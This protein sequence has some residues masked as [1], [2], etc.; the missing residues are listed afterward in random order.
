MLGKNDMKAIWNIHVIAG[1]G[2]TIVIESNHYSPLESV[3]TEY[4]V[5]GTTVTVCSWKCE[6]NYYDVVVDDNEN[7]DAEWYYPQRKEEVSEIE[8]YTA[9]WC[10]VQITN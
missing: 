10:G 6:S 1:S 3:D 8:D 4:L 7:K 5:E 2:E 9:S